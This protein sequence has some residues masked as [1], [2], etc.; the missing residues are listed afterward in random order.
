MKNNFLIA[1]I[2]DAELGRFEW[3]V[4][5]KNNA[6]L[7][8]DWPKN[9]AVK[10][11]FIFPWDKEEV[12]DVEYFLSDEQSR[13]VITRDL[14]SSFSVP[15]AAD[16]MK[17]ICAPGFFNDDRGI[18]VSRAVYVTDWVFRKISLS[19]SAAYA[20]LA[21]G[22]FQ[23]VTLRVVASD[24]SPLTCDVLRYA[25]YENGQKIGEYPLDA[26]SMSGAC[27]FY[28]K[29]EQ[30]VKFILDERYGHLFELI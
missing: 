24:F 13:E 8:W 11:M 2:P 12:P 20:P 22:A 10:L 6:I 26:H 30:R 25:I 18:S 9:R 19:A 21:L 16:K 15:L 17:F 4:D 27:G 28:I 1:E 29:K 7:Q 23:K 14:A 3:S 5:N